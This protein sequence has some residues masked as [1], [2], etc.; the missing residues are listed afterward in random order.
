MLASLVAVG[1]A[2]STSLPDF[3]DYLLFATDFQNGFS[4]YIPMAPDPNAEGG[5]YASKRPISDPSVLTMI[6]DTYSDACKWHNGGDAST[7]TFATNSTA[8]TYIKKSIG[9]IVNGSTS[10]TKYFTFDES[11]VGRNIWCQ[12]YV[13]WALPASIIKGECDQDTS[14]DAFI[15]KVDQSY[16]Q[17]CKF[18]TD[19]AGHGTRLK[20]A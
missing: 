14:C 17:L 20:L 19:D 4:F 13:G 2:F 3:D 16:G 15:M 7:G 9:T 10:S 12:P 8:N 1:L 18:A 11:S 6:C 5:W